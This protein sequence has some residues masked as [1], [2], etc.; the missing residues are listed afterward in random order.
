MI[1]EDTAS[2]L[3]FVFVS[4]PSSPRGGKQDVDSEGSICRIKSIAFIQ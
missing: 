2:L 1:E 4:D 3:D